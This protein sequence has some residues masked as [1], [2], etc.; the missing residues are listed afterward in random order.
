[1]RRCNLVRDLYMTFRN[2][3]RRVNEFVRYRRVTANLNERFPDCT[4]E[5]LADGDD[6]CIICREDMVAMAPG[7]S[8]HSL[9]HHSVPTLNHR[10]LLPPDDAVYA[11]FTGDLCD[12]TKC[13]DT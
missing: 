12:V 10:V 5:E 3:R 7:G 6:V 9:L 13:V 2:F 1:L 4:T 11:H 8:G